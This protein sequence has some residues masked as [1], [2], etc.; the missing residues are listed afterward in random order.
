M[1]QIFIELYVE[2]ITLNIKFFTSIFDCIVVRDED[3]FSELCLGNSIVLLNSYA[4]DVEGHTF[5]GKINQKTN[6][7]GVEIG[8]FVDD[9]DLVYAKAKKFKDIKSISE[10][11]LQDW[12]MTDFRILTIDNYYIRVTSRK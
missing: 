5:H 12:G 10:L 4:G 3:D 6:G 7:I 1:T 8:I 9:I 2:N 11:K